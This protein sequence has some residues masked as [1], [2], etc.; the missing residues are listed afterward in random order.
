MRTVTGGP[1]DGEVWLTS[2]GLDGSGCGPV[3]I[4]D[5]LQGHFKEADRLFT[6]YDAVTDFFPYAV[7][8]AHGVADRGWSRADLPHVAVR[9]KR[10]DEVSYVALGVGVEGVGPRGRD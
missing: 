8:D 4:T 6:G 2:L 1:S 5:S 9:R 10:E 3:R 7:A